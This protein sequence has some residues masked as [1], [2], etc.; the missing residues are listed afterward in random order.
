MTKPNILDQQQ[1][2][3]GRSSFWMDS[4]C[5]R[6]SSR[7]PLKYT[8]ISYV[9]ELRLLFSADTTWRRTRKS[10]YLWFL[11][12]QYMI[13]TWHGTYE[14]LTIVANWTRSLRFWGVMFELNY[15][16][17]VLP[18]I[19]F[20]LAIEKD[21]LTRIGQSAEIQSCHYALKRIKSWQKR[22]TIFK[23]LMRI[24]PLPWHIRM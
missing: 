14:T 24:A 17:A 20:K 4:T 10:K 6:V 5:G 18:L 12:I 22:Y 13:A 11:H 23:H 7:A 2:Y 3:V 15:I 9:I 21:C 16:I 19:L 1:N 8:Y